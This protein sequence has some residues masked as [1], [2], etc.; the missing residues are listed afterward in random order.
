MKKIDIESISISYKDVSDL[1]HKVKAVLSKI[2][3]RRENIQ[4]EFNAI[5]KKE[6]GLRKFLGIKE[7]SKETAAS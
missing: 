2:Q 7:E 1:N 6:R 5:R 3:R 4:T